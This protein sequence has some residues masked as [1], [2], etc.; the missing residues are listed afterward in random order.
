SV[1][2]CRIGKC[3]VSSMIG[4]LRFRPSIFSF[5]DHIPPTFD[6]LLLARS[7]PCSFGAL[8]LFVEHIYMCA[9]RRPPNASRRN[10]RITLHRIGMLSSRRFLFSSQFISV[11][12][13]SP[14]KHFIVIPFR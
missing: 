11:P 8:F 3:G 4:A 9:E 5:V 6:V 12:F 7:D 13:T 14:R 10:E 1:V 2:F